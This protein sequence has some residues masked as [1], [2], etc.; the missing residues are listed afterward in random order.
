MS[1]VVR[2]K[3]KTLLGKIIKKIESELTPKEYKYISPDVPF[4]DTLNV[5]EKTIIESRRDE[6]KL[7]EYDNSEEIKIVV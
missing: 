1:R 6:L 5:E 4:N 3:K 7:A 2:K